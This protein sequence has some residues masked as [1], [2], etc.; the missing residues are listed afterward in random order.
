[1][2]YI[3][4]NYDEC[5][6]CNCCALACSFAKTKQFNLSKSNIKIV[7]FTEAGDVSFP[8][9]CLQCLEPVCMEA[10][11]VEAIYRD[12]RTGVVLINEHICDACEIC[13]KECPFGG[14]WFD[15]EN[16][17]AMK[18]DLCGGDPECV[19]YC[20]YGALKFVTLEEATMKQRE[21]EARRISGILKEF[22]ESSSLISY[23]QAQE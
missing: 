6:E 15:T 4:V 3:M 10:C 11:P 18:C 23:G 14:V 8:I 20:A 22:R 12:K 9:L 19:K 16:S 1:M 13:V 17:K 7:T 5:R 21:Q 2:K